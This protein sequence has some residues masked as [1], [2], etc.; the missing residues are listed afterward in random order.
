[1][2]SYSMIMHYN[3]HYNTQLYQKALNPMI[4]LCINSMPE[5]E[6][7]EL[8]VMNNNSILF[9]KEDVR[10][11]LIDEAIIALVYGSIVTIAHNSNIIVFKFADNTLTITS[12]IDIFHNHIIP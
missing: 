12:E 11:N 1:M 7:V 8:F 9:V 6:G 4:S 2:Y 10:E 3:T 5:R